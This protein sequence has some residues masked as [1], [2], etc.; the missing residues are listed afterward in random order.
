[1]RIKLHWKLTFIFCLLIIT[2]LMFVYA[3]LNSHLKDYLQ[4]RIE[5]T[6]SN[7]LSLS[8][9]II[10]DSLERPTAAHELQDIAKSIERSL[11]L[12]VTVIGP[13]G[14]VKADSEMTD[15]ELGDAEN[16]LNRSEI[17]A[18]AK[19]GVGKSTR[20]SVTKKTNML[21]MAAPLGARG[22]AGYLRLAMHLSDIE[23]IE[24]KW[25]NILAAALA[26][27]LALTF[28]LGYTISV[29]I[30]KPLERISLAAGQIAKGDFSKRIR[31]YSNDEIGDLSKTLDY[32]AGEI[33]NKMRKVSYE[34]AKLDTVISSMFE[35]IMLTDEKG[36]ILMMNP[37][38]RKLLLI[39]SS[40]EG[41]KPIEILRNKKIQDIIDNI[42]KTSRRFATEETLAT[43][44]EEKTIL[45]TGAPVVRN[46]KMQGAILVF[47]DITELRRLERI[48]QDFVANVSHELRTPLS[49]IKGYAETLLGGALQDKNNSRE[50]TEIIHKE[51][52]RLSKIIDDLLDIARIESGKMDMAFL[53]VEA[54]PLVAKVCNILKKSALDKSIRMD[55]YIPEDTPRIRADEGRLAQVLLNLLDNAIKYT[56]EHGSVKVGASKADG[57][58]QFDIIDTGIGI[59]DNDIPRI[60]ERFYRVDKARSRELGGTGLGLS[61]VKHLVQAHGGRVWVRSALGKG[62]TFSFTIPAA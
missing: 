16:H 60:F 4:Q 2:I 5:Y 36:S 21:Y 55:I 61:I 33:E 3:Y 30:S 62:S 53:A 12:R 34:E 20:F 44:P 57:F 6:L 26:L 52:E 19:N 7:E 23:A 50:F 18:A 14:A 22:E 1:M 31:M 8:K 24:M 35:G 25:R 41:K 54:G 43:L 15:E 13:D 40:P 56:Q 10:E 46:E 38:L 11:D 28:L 58:V 49:N 29:W 9:N 42:I 45:I 27:A 39:D 17:Q 47:H 51:S 48:R 37:S 32:M 59:P